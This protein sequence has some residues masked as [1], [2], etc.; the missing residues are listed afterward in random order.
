MPTESP[1]SICGSFADRV[2][3]V[4]ARDEAPRAHVSLLAKD[5]ALAAAFARELGV[6]CELGK[7]AATGFAD[8]LRTGLADADDSA[9]LRRG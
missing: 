7:T 4:L 5:S 3:R 9:M 6:S 2:A 1:P 8:A